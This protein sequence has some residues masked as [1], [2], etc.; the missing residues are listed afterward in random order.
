[1]FHEIVCYSKVLLAIE[2]VTATSFWQSR[3]H[4]GIHLY[5]W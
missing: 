4:T 3:G 5:V 2:T 1:M